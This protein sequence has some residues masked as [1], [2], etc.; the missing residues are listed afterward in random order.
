MR[1]YS[2]PIA[3]GVLF[4]LALYPFYIWPLAAVALTPLF[5]FINQQASAKAAFKGGV[6]TGGVIAV[7]TFYFTLAQLVPAAYEPAFAVAV[8]LASVPA[9]AILAA[10][11]GCA[12]AAAW[13]LRTPYR[14]LNATVISAAYVFVEL[15]IFAMFGGYYPSSIAYALVAVPLTLKIA[16]LGGAVSAIWAWAALQALAV[17]VARARR[18][19]DILAPLCVAAVLVGCVWYSPPARELTPMRVS[20]LQTAPHSVETSLFG[21]FDGGV[22]SDERLAPLIAAAGEQSDLVIYPYSVVPDVYGQAEA[23]AIGEWLSGVSPTPVAIWASRTESGAVYDEVNIWSDKEVARIQKVALY[24][25]SDYAP[26]WVEA[27]GLEKGGQ[28]INPGARSR[29]LVGGVPVGGLLCSELHQPG[30]A[31]ERSKNVAWLLSPGYDGFFPG[32]LMGETS[33]AAARIRAAENGISIVRADPV[34]PSVIVEADGS[35]QSK[36]SFGAAGTLRGSVGGER[37]DTVYAKTGSAP[38]FIVM[39]ALLCAGLV[40]RK[41]RSPRS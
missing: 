12:M 30:E 2:L 26:A 37:L 6:I 4:A 41:F 11:M 40:L 24:P 38:A 9:A 22:F 15:L 13:Y 31:R 14:L 5:Y 28:V 39:G 33:V 17:E 3:S 20:I 34:G 7:P 36:L 18:R 19:Q 32:K 23:Q 25:L 1:P 16:A 8:Q 10:A 21:S 29:A 27:L 35:L